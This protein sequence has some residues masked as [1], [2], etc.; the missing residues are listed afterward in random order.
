MPV[1]EPILDVIVMDLHSPLLLG[2]G[3]M[4]NY[5]VNWNIV[6]PTLEITSP[7][8][9]KKSIAFTPKALQVL[10]SEHLGITCEGE[11][12]AKLPDGIYQIRY[13][14]Y[15]AY[16]YYVDKTFLRVEKL[17]EKFDSYFLSLELT[18]KNASS[19]QRKQLEEVELYIQGAI[20][21]ANNCAT[22]LAL[23]LYQKADKILNSLIKTNG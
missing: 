10:N 3:D 18:C 1:T 15:P 23:E 13:S 6:S 2:L 16:K 22:N 21:A 19:T 5:P 9:D 8:Y 20:A 7:G 11:C 12:N 17:Y 4:S 14:I